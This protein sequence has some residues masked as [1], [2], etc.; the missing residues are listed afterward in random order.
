LSVGLLCIALALAVQP[1]RRR[2]DAEGIAGQGAGKGERSGIVATLRGGVGL[3]LAMPDMRRLALASVSYAAAQL[4]LA[5]FL[6]TF[7]ITENGFDL[8]GAGAVLAV[9]NGAGIECRNYFTN[10]G[11]AST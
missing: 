7:L 3:V 2:F 1:L 4:C 5:S 8:V 6:V 11:Y 9:G 10:S